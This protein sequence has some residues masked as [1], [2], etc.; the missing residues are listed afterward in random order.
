MLSRRKS[1]KNEQAAGM[2]SYVAA[3]RIGMLAS[4]AGAL[5][6]V[7]GFEAYGFGKH[8]AYMW[9]Y[10]VMAALVVIGIATTLI[11]TEPET[12]NQAETAHKK[13][14]ATPRDHDCLHGV[15]G[16]PIDGLR[17]GGFIFVILFKFTDA[18]AGIMTAPFVIDLGFSKNEYA[19]IIKASALLQP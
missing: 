1:E 19:A 7:S 15:L 18:L 17:S 16:F 14:S 6:L 8:A 11:A 4:T 2:A 9:G 3:Y 10:I 13:E 12:S 5:F